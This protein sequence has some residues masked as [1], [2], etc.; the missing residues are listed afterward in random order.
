MP[1][2][3]NKPSQANALNAKSEKVRK[4]QTKQAQ[5]NGYL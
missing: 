1:V 4:A 3:N 2:K 5:K